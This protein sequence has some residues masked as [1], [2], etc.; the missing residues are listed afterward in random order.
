MVS[1]GIIICT[2]G[3]WSS[4][5]PTCVRTSTTCP[6]LESPANGRIHFSGKNHTRASFY[7][8]DGFILRGDGILNCT[9]GTWSSSPPTCIRTSTTCPQLESPANGRIHFSGNDHTKAIFIVMKTL[10]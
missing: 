5:P 10:P 1:P 8:K 6:Q 4:S 9:D 7:C 2:D 3:T